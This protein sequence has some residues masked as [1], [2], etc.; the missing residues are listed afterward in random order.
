MRWVIAVGL[1]VHMLRWIGLCKRTIAPNNS[2]GTG[3]KIVLQKKWH[4]N[5]LTKKVAPKLWPN[6]DRNIPFF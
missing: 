4:Q 3:N 6:F 5:C 1:D 2:A